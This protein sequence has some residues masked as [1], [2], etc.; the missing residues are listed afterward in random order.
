MS[1]PLIGK[2]NRFRVFQAVK[3]HIE[4]NGRAPTSVEVSE[5]L[6]LSNTS[7]ARHMRALQNADGLRGLLLTS[8]E[9]KSVGLS[10]LGEQRREHVP[11]LTELM[12]Q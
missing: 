2:V 7:V 4:L 1:R 6:G 5:Q 8:G 12:E 9:A 11:D 10:H 3:E